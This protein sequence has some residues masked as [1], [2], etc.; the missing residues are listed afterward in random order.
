MSD[1]KVIDKFQIL[2]LDTGEITEIFDVTVPIKQRIDGI[3]Y[4]KAQVESRIDLIKQRVKDLTLDRK[5]LEELLNDIKDATIE[6]L[7]ANGESIVRGLE[8]KAWISE[9]SKKILSVNEMYINEEDKEFTITIKG[10]SHEKKSEIYGLVWEKL[11]V[12]TKDIKVEGKIN[13]DILPKAY[14]EKVKNT[15]VSFSRTGATVN[16]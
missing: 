13:L 3:G 8:T 2:S 1:L 4:L 9:R 16:E 10:L 6:G 7:L 11:G 5:Q 15:I 14:V 12:P